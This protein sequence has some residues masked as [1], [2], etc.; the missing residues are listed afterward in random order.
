[1][2]IR[3]ARRKAAWESTDAAEIRKVEFTNKNG[4]LDLRPSVY[5]VDASEVIRTFAEHAAA[6]PIDPPG[7]ALG[8][9]M[10]GI[11]LELNNEPG[12]KR[13]AFTRER[14]REIV[15]ETEAAIE[16]LISSVL[17]TLASRLHSIP[18]AEVY[19][20]VASRFQVADDEWV[21]LSES[22]AAKEW[23]RTLAIKHLPKQ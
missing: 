2:I 14:H 23:L 3:F 22:T 6:A 18:K 8:V 21:E 20:Y 11:R 7:S 5:D 9:D 10:S 19:A 12:N 4:E 13:F 16:Q 15:V 1:L 17:A